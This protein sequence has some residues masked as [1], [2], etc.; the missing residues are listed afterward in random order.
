MIWRRPWRHRA[1]E[2]AAAASPFSTWADLNREAPRCVIN[3]H[4]LDTFTLFDRQVLLVWGLGRWLK[5][6]EGRSSRP[7]LSGPASPH[8]SAA[9]SLKMKNAKLLWAS[10]LLVTP[11]CTTTAAR[12]LGS[13]VDLFTS[14]TFS[15]GCRGR[16]LPMTEMS[17][18]K[19]VIQEKNNSS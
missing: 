15:A 2:A 14:V 13:T 8:V 17:V 5:N 3:N 12:G 19:S 10:W 7:V 6:D 4:S 11:P 18:P 16:E 1:A 9:M